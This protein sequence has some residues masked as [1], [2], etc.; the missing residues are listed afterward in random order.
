MNTA[1]KVGVVVGVIAGLNIAGWWTRKVMM[2]KTVDGIISMLKEEQKNPDEFIR[3]MN[4]DLFKSQME[5]C[6]GMKKVYFKKGLKVNDDGS[7][8]FIGKEATC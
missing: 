8:E 6:P 3:K 2:D 1:G 7:Y 5:H 4:Q